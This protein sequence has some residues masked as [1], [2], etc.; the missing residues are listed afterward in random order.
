MAWLPGAT[1]LAR[2]QDVDNVLPRTRNVHQGGE[3]VVL[4]HGRLI[5]R[6]LGKVRQPFERV[7]DVLCG[8]SGREHV[9]GTGVQR[10]RTERQMNVSVVDSTTV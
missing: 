7:L 9:V 8:E 1:A 6:L 4:V 5:P 10:R 2:A 3:L